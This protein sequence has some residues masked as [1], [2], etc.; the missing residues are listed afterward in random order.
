MVRIEP[1]SPQRVGTYKSVRLRA[2]QD[3]PFAFGSTYAKE[4]AL[5][6]ADWER[7][8]VEWNNGRSAGYVAMDGE[9]ACGLVAVFLDEHEQ[10]HAH[11]V[12]MWVDP[13][14][15]QHGVGRLLVEAVIAWSLAQGVRLLKLTV[16]SN[17][18]VATRFYERLG[19]AKTGRTEPYPNDA[20]LFEYEMARALHRSGASET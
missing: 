13:A 9:T 17:N 19:F 14:Y 18:D 16:T 2:L 1:I 4:A 12:S 20:S 3:S 15:R 10:T 6:D 7:R 5:S 8:A 11:Q